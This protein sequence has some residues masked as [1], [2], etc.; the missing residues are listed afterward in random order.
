MMADKT[1]KEY[2]TPVVNDYGSVETITEA[3]EGLGEDQDF[4]ILNLKG[5]A[6]I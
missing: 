2:Q 6:G 4:E 1:T 3:K 5:S